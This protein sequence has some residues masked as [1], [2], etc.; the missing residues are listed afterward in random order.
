MCT[1]VGRTVYA[2]CRGEGVHAADL[3]QPPEAIT[4]QAQL[5][6]PHKWLRVR[7]LAS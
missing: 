5:D 4:N 1:I 2:W 6:R 3:I 7:S